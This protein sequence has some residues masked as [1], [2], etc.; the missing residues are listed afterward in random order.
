MPWHASPSP[1]SL[2][3]GRVLCTI[4]STILASCCPWSFIT[5]G[6]VS[7]ALQQMTHPNRRHSSITVQLGVLA[8]PFFFSD[9]YWVLVKHYL[10]HLPSN[11]KEANDLFHPLRKLRQRKGWCPW[12]KLPM[13]LHFHHTPLPQP[14]DSPRPLSL[15]WNRDR[16]YCYNF[17]VH[18]HTQEEKNIITV[19]FS[20][21]SSFVFCSFTSL[22]I[23]SWHLISCP[24]SGKYDFFLNQ[25][26]ASRKCPT[27]A[28]V[29]TGITARISRAV[30]FLFC[31]QYKLKTPLKTTIT[32]WV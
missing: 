8:A 12:P 24:V 16:N 10:I 29:V 27:L 14:P 23:T 30:D 5:L 28:S 18:L 32:L 3:K 2:N 15:W 6:I 11:W 26:I 31:S 13:R 4:K 22:L 19:M 25:W 21:F 9:Q 17:P 7:M 20:L 1:C